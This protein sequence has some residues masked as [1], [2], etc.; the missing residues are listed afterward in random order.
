MK[1]FAIGLAACGGVA[2][3][4]LFIVGPALAYARAVPALPAFTVF[5]LGMLLGMPSSLVGLGMLVRSERGAAVWLALMG[6]PAAGFL[7]YSIVS[8]RGAPA[9]NDI[10]TDL[11]YPPQF[12]HALT[13]P[14]N[15]GRDMAFPSEFKEAIKES[16]PDVQTLAMPGTVDDIF[17]KAVELARERKGMEVTSTVITPAESVFEG[18]AASRLFGFV[19]DIVVRVTKV[20]EGGCVVDMRSKSRDGR[21]DLGANAERIRTFLTGLQSG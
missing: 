2:S 9:I 12:V 7:L 10:S 21:G 4:T 8:L 18:Y 15:A 16:Y 3:I 17:A 19:D 5:G 14:E 11:V 1:G 13:L 6:L 20:D